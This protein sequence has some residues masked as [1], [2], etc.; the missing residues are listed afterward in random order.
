M[1]PSIDG[2]VNPTLLVWSIGMTESTYV[3]NF[4]ISRINHDSADLASILQ[5]HV[6]PRGAA[7]DGFVN[8]IAGR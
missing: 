1:R 8:S 7:V 5:A 6:R 3:N 2:F 4:R